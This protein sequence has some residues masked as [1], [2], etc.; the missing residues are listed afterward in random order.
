MTR[1]QETLQKQ[2]ID[3][4]LQA[5]RAKPLKQRLERSWATKHSGTQGCSNSIP[6]LGIENVCTC[7]GQQ[8]AQRESYVFCAFLCS[9]SIGQSGGSWRADC[10]RRWTCC[11]MSTKWSAT[12]TRL[13]WIYIF[14]CDVCCLFKPARMS[15]WTLLVGSSNSRPDCGGMTWK[16]R[17]RDGIAWPALPSLNKLELDFDLDALVQALQI[18]QLVS[19]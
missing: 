17:R 9:W 15:H 7:L 18:R 14:E 16:M 5:Q 8:C 1:L 13:D 3:V 2:A 12:I 10:K 4:D 19:L 11:T 6:P